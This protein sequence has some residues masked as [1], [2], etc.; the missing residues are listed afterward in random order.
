MLSCTD[1]LTALQIK[2]DANLELT[3]D[4]ILAAVAKDCPPPL[5][6]FFSYPVSGADK[7]E[8]SKIPTICSFSIM[9]RLV[10]ESSWSF[11]EH[12]A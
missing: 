6:V 5:T 9:V 3:P 8:Q 11:Q 4:N 12:F 10:V 7:C 1:L 2:Q